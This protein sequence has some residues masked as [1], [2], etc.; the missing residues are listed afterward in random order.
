MA[1][2]CG[3]CYEIVAI[4][5]ADFDVLEGESWLVV[6]GCRDGSCELFRAFGQLCRK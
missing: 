5:L 4:A 2:P 6:G 1:I 3:E